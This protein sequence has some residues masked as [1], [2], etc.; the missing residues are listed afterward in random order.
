MNKI[1]Y[2]FFCFA[3]CVVLS[4]KNYTCNEMKTYTNVSFEDLLQNPSKYDNQ[5]V[6]VTGV[7]SGNKNIGPLIFKGE[8]DFRSLKYK[9]A[10]YI[11]NQKGSFVNVKHGGL[12]VVQGIFRAPKD[13][14]AHIFFAE[15]IDVVS[16]TGVAGMNWRGRKP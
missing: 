16:V 1:I 12:V 11:F 15:I 2:C 8:D 14:E 9:S 4:S 3:F 10:I 7:Y 6:S 13:N 5:P